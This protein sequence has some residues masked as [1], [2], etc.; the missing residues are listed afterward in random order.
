MKTALA[1]AH[2]WVAR[3]I[4]GALLLQVFFAGLG[5]FGAAPFALHATLGFAV[6]F[7]SLVLLGLALAARIARGRSA[8]LCALMV[9]QV[10]LIELGGV[11]PLIPALHPVNALA[12]IAGLAHALARGRGADTTPAARE[13]PRRGG[14]RGL[15]RAGGEGPTGSR[16]ALAP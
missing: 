4:F 2:R 15:S 6:I 11:S 9:A 8:L 14:R 13:P 10:L 12:L 7:A 3:L 16:V 5:I 1:R